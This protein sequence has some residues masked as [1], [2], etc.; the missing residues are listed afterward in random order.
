[1][2]L[3]RA[4]LA[5]KPPNHVPLGPRWLGRPQRAIVVHHQAQGGFRHLAAGQGPLEHK[6]TQQ[7]GDLRQGCVWGGEGGEPARAVVALRQQ[8]GKGEA[9]IL[10][11]RWW[12]AP[13]LPMEGRC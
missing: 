2:R 12:G 1:M 6:V 8:G 9:V 13:P 4:A 5:Q 7:L 11:G 10:R 3:S